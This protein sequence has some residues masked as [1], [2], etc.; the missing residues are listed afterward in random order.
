MLNKKNETKSKKNKTEYAFP[1]T[2]GVDSGSLTAKA[3]IMDGRRQVIAENVVQLDYVSQKAVEMAMNNA[4]VS[5]GLDR[6]N[7]SYTVG[8]GYGRRKLD[9]ADKAITE[10]TCHARGANYVYPECRMVID[11]GGQDSKV[12]ALDDKGNVINF[13]MNDRC[14]AG[15]GQFLEVMARALG[16]ELQQI[17]ELSIKAKKKLEVSSMCVVFAETEVISLVADGNDKNDILGALHDSIARRVAGLVG[18]VGLVKPVI[19]T[20]G[21][22]KNIGMVKA[23]ERVLNISMHV[24]RDPQI[25]GAIG[26]AIIAQDLMSSRVRNGH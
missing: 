4:L 9:F 21:V 16:F 17:G 22:A 14:A 24:P 15:T 3:V 19:M 10:I 26:A 8:T 7:I 6:Q 2:M 25:I 5:S 12:I 13:A 18:R 20:G 11:I 23:L 1:I